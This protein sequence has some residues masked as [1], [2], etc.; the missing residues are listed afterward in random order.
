M[1]LPVLQRQQPKPAT[2]AAAAVTA[3]CLK[4]KRQGGKT[5]LLLLSFPLPPASSNQHNSSI[6]TS[7]L[8]NERICYSFSFQSYRLTS[9]EDKTWIYKRNLLQCPKRFIYRLFKHK[10]HVLFLHWTLDCPVS[11]Q[12]TPAGQRKSCSFLFPL[13]IWK[14]EK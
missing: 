2:V 11:G 6:H 13:S 5:P 3:H 8:N 4:D 14:R 1:L 9:R 12:Q 10:I 7:A